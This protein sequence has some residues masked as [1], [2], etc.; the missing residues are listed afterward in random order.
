MKSKVFERIL[1]D[2]NSKP[3]WFKFK[4][5]LKIEIVTLKTLGIKK[6]LKL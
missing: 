4:L 2:I 6:Y 1:N 3:I 5:W